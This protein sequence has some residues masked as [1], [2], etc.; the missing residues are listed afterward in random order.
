[1]ARR[2]GYA[3]AW[4]LAQAGAEKGRDVAILQIVAR[5]LQAIAQRL[6]QAPD[7]NKLA[8]LDLL[9]IDLIP[10][11]AARAP[12]VFKLSGQAPD[13]RLPAGTRVAAPPPPER[14][15]QIIFETERA[16]GLASASLQEVVS[17]W[18]GRDQYIDHSAE[19][20]AGLPFQPFKKPLLQDTPH[21]IYLAHDTLLAL[22]G[23]SNVDVKFDLT[24]PGSEPLSLIWE[25]W[26]GDVWRTFL[27]NRPSCLEDP[28][29]FDGTGGLQSSGTFHLKA[30]CAETKKRK[31]NGVEAQ[32]IRGRLTEPLPPN[33]DQVLPE[34]DNI[35][36][37]TVIQQYTSTAHSVSFSPFE[38]GDVITVP[39]VFSFV[40]DDIPVVA[41][42]FPSFGGIGFFNFGDLTV[43]DPDPD[44]NGGRSVRLNNVVLFFVLGNLSGTVDFISFDFAGFENG[45][46]VGVNGRSTLITGDG[47]KVLAPG[48]RGIVTTDGDKKSITILGEVEGLSVGLNGR[49]SNFFFQVSQSA[50]LLP[51][52]AFSGAN[53]LDVSKAFYPLGENP[54]PGDAFY[55]TNEELFSK[56]KAVAT[57]FMRIAETPEQKFVVEPGEGQG[58]TRTP[59]THV[60]I[61]EYWNG[62]KWARI[63]LTPKKK[64]VNLPDFDDSDEFTFEVPEDMEPVKINDQEASQE[65]RWMRARLES[66]GYGFITS[67][68]WTDTQSDPPRP[69][70]FDTVV[71]QPPALAEFKLRYLWTFGPFHPERVFAHNDFQY[72]DRT[73]EARW[74]GQIFQPFKPVTDV[75]PALYLGFDK[76]LPVDRLNLF[77]DVV[78][79]RGD[80]LGPEL[81]WQ[82]WDG[83]SWEDLTVEDETR[84]LRVPGMVSL[85]G[86]EDS[87]PLARFGT[88]RHW[89]R[90]R[91]KGDGP[92]GEPVINGLFSNAVWAIQRQ[93][94]TNDALG[95]S[96]GQPN[97]RFAFRQFPV[98]GGDQG[99]INERVEVREL[100]GAR[101]NTEWRIVAAD[102]FANDA[103]I[104]AEFEDLLSREGDQVEIERGG[105]RLL[106]DRNKR[107]TEVWVRW[108]SREHFFFS[109]PNDRHYVLERARGRILF[110]DGDR[111][112]LPPLGAAILAREYRTGGGMAGNVV[113]NKITQLLGGVAG[114]E[115]VFNP[116]P[117]EGG[118]DTETLEA[119]NRRGPQTLRHRGRAL[120]PRDYETFARETSPAVAF[121]RAIPTRDAQGRRV[122][123]WVTLLIIPQSEEPRPWP[124][125][126]LREQVRKRIEAHTT[127]DLAAAH[128][129][130]V[131]GPDYIAIDVEATVIPRD[132]AEAGAVETRAL[133][134]LQ[135]FLHP[136]RGGPG[137]PASPGWEMG[138]D[139][140]LSDVAAVLER[141][142]GV[143]FVREL[144]LLLDGNPRGERVS[145]ADDRIVVAG[146][147][148]LKLSQF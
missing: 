117:A 9:G 73:E 97:N 111:G 45:M 108:L 63:L 57:I 21:A 53:K 102:V 133:E 128:R 43:I 4:L 89:L 67:V 15:D 60:V 34:V 135:N 6:N 42:S 61:W 125:F 55:F 72:E 20:L 70:R 23:K 109:G 48:V 141:V 114:V 36:L 136:L 139:V 121:A 11:Q 37:Q 105:L 129:I 77:F 58:T 142:E 76:K 88:E 22:A 122:P 31:V 99:G 68:F 106:R 79:Q 146:R 118:A 26:D 41:I 54:R 130:H 91:L 7:K 120:L 80:T 103:K 84:N 16:A 40:E 28:E 148:K 1:M 50:T 12:M 132:P 124:S 10:A 83:F 87:Q 127:A 110:G 86:P 144:T 147:I 27:N 25:Y 13:I 82:Y 134:A 66:G 74:P 78:E 33:P 112:K 65:A 131:T 3:R 98:L 126:G 113:A 47:E 100:F 62:V 90:A 24:T 38:A 17:L 49:V 2:P 59:L 115:K 30:D 101:A 18:S 95:A 85:I 107:V 64:P 94:V 71:S 81:L 138:R 116:K 123:G 51:D 137:G 19:T 5:Y 46:S 75:T 104:I 52:K 140:F 32:W 145:V 39:F 56:P 14:S 44:F 92:P 96:D 35:R 143:D 69:N 93:T 8:F 29:Q 119:L